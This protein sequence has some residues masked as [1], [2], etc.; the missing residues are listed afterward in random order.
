MHSFRNQNNKSLQEVADY[1]GISKQT[2]SNYER[3]TRE[4]NIDTIKQLAVYYGV[5]LNQLL[6]FDILNIHNYQDNKFDLLSE[7]LNYLF[8]SSKFKRIDV[9]QMNISLP[10]NENKHVDFEDI[11][12]FWMKDDSVFF[13]IK[14]VDDQYTPLFPKDRTLIVKVTNKFAEKDIVVI[15]KDN[16]THL[17]SVITL[18]GT[19]LFYNLAN[20]RVLGFENESPNSFQLIGRIIEVRQK[21]SSYI[22]DKNSFIIN[23]DNGTRRTG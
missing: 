3:G 19:P 22:D 23:C 6:N 18:N 7:K 1:L 12:R 20:N 16:S 13:G 17:Y 8:E 2:L 10:L 15:N 4:P 9:Y 5:D 11:P 21:L 14:L